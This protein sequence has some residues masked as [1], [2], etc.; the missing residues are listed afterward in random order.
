MK[1]KSVEGKGIKDPEGDLE[2]VLGGKS[3]VPPENLQ[4]GEPATIFRSIA[5]GGG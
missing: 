5:Y 3:G 4:S 1:V 2:R